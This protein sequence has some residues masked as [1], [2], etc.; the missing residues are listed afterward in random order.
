MSH[1]GT[2]RIMMRERGLT[3]LE[4][5]I[6]LAVIGLLMVVGYSGLRRVR[7]SE[8]AEN[9]VEIVQ[10]MRN[11]YLLATESSKQTRVVFDFDKQ[12]FYIEGCPEARA[13]TRGKVEA[14]VA[15]ADGV[16]AGPGEQLSLDPTIP[17]ELLRA[18]TPEDAVKVAAALAGT[19]VGALRC[20]VA[21]GFDA[22][23]RGF[24]RSMRTDDTIKLRQIHV[25]HLEEPA[26]GGVVAV[27]FFPL[28][29]SEKAVIEIGT[30]DGKYFSVISRGLGGRIEVREGRV[31]DV[32]AILLRDASGDEE[33]AR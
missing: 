25:Q 23:D 24:V 29:Y 6:T 1:R 26:T 8:L 2:E 13:L 16:P 14:D 33:A 32:D 7:D 5:M 28:G 4:L 21:G 17:P 10:L 20:E 12:T 31:E 30:D 9:A 15:T 11:G 27:N 3:L 18:D 22:K 19:A